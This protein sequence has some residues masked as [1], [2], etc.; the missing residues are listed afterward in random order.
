[1]RLGRLPVGA[2]LAEG[3]PRASG[4]MLD[5]LPVPGHLAGEP[6]AAQLA[7]LP[8]SLGGAIAR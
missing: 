6:L 8:P 4:E 1:M 2:R 3:V 7:R 5:L